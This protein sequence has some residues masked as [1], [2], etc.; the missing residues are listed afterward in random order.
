MPYIG[1]IEYHWCDERLKWIE[2][3]FTE[4]GEWVEV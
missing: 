2:M 1:Q 4:S 3:E